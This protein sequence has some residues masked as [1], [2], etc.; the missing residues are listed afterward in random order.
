MVFTSPL[1]GT[2]H[3]PLAT[4]TSVNNCFFVVVVVVVFIYTTTVNNCYLFT[5]SP[6]VPPTERCQ[7]RV[8]YEQYGF[9]VFCLKKLSNKLFPKY[10]KK[11]TKSGLEA[12]TG[13]ALSV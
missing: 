12:L 9:P 5:D 1:R 13:K 3:S 8:S 7:A 11:V 2:V 4:S 10:T 6:P